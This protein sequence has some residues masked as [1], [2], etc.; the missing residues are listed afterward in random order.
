MGILG[1][2]SDAHHGTK[3]TNP[4]TRGFM[5]GLDCSA[6]FNESLKV[7]FFGESAILQAKP[8]FPI[9]GGPLECVFVNRAQRTYPRRNETIAA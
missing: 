2:C 1:C 3:K 9:S 4:P 7:P 6:A 8:A 5:L